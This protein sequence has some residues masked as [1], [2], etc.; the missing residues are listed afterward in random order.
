[1][2]RKIELTITELTVLK[3]ATAMEKL[4]LEEHLTGMENDFDSEHLKQLL[5]DQIARLNNVHERLSE[6]L[7]SPHG[8]D[9]GK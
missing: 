7:K 2:K 4:R 3:H 8:D 6:A 5:T 1:M 9:N